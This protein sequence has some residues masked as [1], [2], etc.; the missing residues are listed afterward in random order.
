MDDQAKKIL[1]DIARKSVEAAVKHE[2]KPLFSCNHPDLQGKQGVFVTLKT[3]GQLRGCIGC[4]ISDVPLY[5]LV[6]EMAFSSAAE[7]PRFEFNRIKPTEL[8]HLEIEISVLSPLKPIDNPLDFELGKHGIF[9]KKDFHVGCFLPQVATE[10][11]WSK[12]EFLS[13]CCASKAGLS[14]NAWKHKD[15]EIYT[16][17]TEMI[18]EKK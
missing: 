9:I 16:F 18:E 11:G 13:H 2:P 4:F 14:A 3:H 17:T 7:D 1:L 6:S 8:D 15:V 10:T 12:E 5:Q